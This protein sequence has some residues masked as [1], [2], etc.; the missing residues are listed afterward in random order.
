MLLNAERE[1]MDAAARDGFVKAF[2]AHISKDARVYRQGVQPVIGIDSV[3][4]FLSKRRFTQ[5]WKPMKAEVARSADL[6]YTYG[7]YETREKGVAAA[8]E[9]GY[10]VRVW[11]G[12]T[13]NRWLVVFDMAIPLPPSELE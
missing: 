6:G 12:G 10:Y 3:S 5:S 13:R 2:V 9:K 8:M 7:S 4:A 1:L 11:K